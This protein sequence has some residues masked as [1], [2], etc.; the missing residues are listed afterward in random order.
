MVAGFLK[1]PGIA[2]GEDGGS[3]WGAFGIGCE[4]VVEEDAFACDAVKGRGVDPGATIST[5]VGPGLIIGNAEEDVWRCVIY[6]PP[7]LLYDV[8]QSAIE[9][10]RRACDERS[11]FRSEEGDKSASIGGFT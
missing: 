3:G 9:V 4:G 5:G 7:L 6:L 10:N 2:T 1:L 11:A 8:G